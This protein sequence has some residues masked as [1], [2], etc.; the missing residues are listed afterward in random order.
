MLRVESNIYG[1]SPKVLDG[2]CDSKGIYLWDVLQVE[3]FN[4][5][6]Q[7]DTRVLE[8]RQAIL[9]IEHDAPVQE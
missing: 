5:F 6:A 1:N 2:C 9:A 7:R 8:K 4:T 3:L